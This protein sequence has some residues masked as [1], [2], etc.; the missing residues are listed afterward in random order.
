M[1]VVSAGNFV[2]V[3]VSVQNVGQQLGT[4]KISA[5]VVPHT[6]PASA[7][8]QTFYNIKGYTPTNLPPAGADVVQAAAATPVGSTTVLTMFSNSW[9]D[10]NP[11][12]YSSQQ[13]FDVIFTITVVETSA[14]FTFLG[15]SVLIHQTLA[16]AHPSIVNVVYSVLIS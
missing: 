3:D 7:K 14:T 9:A 4:F 13:V 5:V 11:L 8:V 2:Q 6:Q 16:P 1:P 15:D 12:K 10:G